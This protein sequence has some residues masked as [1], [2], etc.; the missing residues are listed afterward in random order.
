MLN[1]WLSKN[2]KKLEEKDVLYLRCDGQRLYNAFEKVLTVKSV[3]GHKD[4]ADSVERIIEHPTIEDYMD[5]QL[6]AVLARQKNSGGLPERIMKEFKRSQDTFTYKE[7]RAVETRERVLKPIY[8]YIDTH[9]S[10]T[11]EI[12]SEYIYKNLFN[13]KASKRR[14]FTRWKECALYAKNSLRDYGIKLLLILDGVDALHFNTDAGVN[15]YNLLVPELIN[16][17][18]RKGEFN[19]LRL[20][21]MRERTWIDIQSKDGSIL[22]WDKSV[23]P[24][25][26]THISPDINEL[27]KKR[28]EWLRVVLTDISSRDTS[29]S[30]INTIS[31][32]MTCLPGADILHENFRNVIV[33]SATLAE[34][35]RFRWHQLG[36]KPDLD[37]KKQASQLMK[38][39]LFLNGEFYLQT[40]KTF[41]EKNREKGYP[42]IN[43]F[44]IDQNIYPQLKTSPSNL[45]LRIRMLELLFNTRLK[46]SHLD[47][48]LTEGFGYDVENVGQVV[49]DARAFGWIDS[50]LDDTERKDVTLE[51]SKTGKYLLEVLLND[52]DVLYMLALDSPTPKYFIENG[53]FPVHT[54]Y[55]ERSGY[56]GFAAITIVSFLHWLSIN[57]RHDKYLINYD[58]IDGIYEQIFL[59]QNHIERIAKDLG[60]KL[61]CAHEDDLRIFRSAY[62]ILCEP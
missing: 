10:E 37:L 25:K 44:W 17:T 62:G 29:N 48:L 50:K 32:A 41:V 54:N 42:Y 7:A 15:I 52:F 26:I 30:I 58:K 23:N 59:E 35:I 55:I 13:D 22:G 49:K 20:T 57:F 33:N 5:F 47:K 16:F 28:I 19:E 21:V 36:K 45:F 60:E 8:W 3:R 6:L 11:L 31:A 40:Q 24:K 14:E 39:N 53:F 61:S 56:I 9:V 46:Q 2:Q 18:L 4:M 43:P 12:E 38:R 34:Q 1:H 27:M 51:L